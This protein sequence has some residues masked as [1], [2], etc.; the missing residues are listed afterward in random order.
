MDV[1][2]G[3]V[4]GLLLSYCEHGNEPSGQGITEGRGFR[5]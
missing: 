3:C 4:T 5:D 1:K 2:T